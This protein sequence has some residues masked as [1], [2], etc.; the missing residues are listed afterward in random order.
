MTDA[1]ARLRAL[2][3]E[4]EPPARDPAFVAAVAHRLER[5]RLAQDVAWLAAA[6]AVGGLV[7]WALWPGLQPLL[8]AAGQNLAPVAGALA[9][10]GAVVALLEGRLGGVFAPES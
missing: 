1:D 3:A 4:D 6:A 10:A 5:R 2:F 8:A 7:L 9:L